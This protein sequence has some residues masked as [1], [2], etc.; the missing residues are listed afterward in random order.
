MAEAERDEFSD[1][2]ESFITQ[3]PDGFFIEIKEPCYQCMSQGYY[4]GMKDA[5]LFE[6]GEIIKGN[7]TPNHELRPLNRAAGRKVREWLDSLPSN[8]VSITMDD[9]IEATVLLSANPKLKDLEPD[10]IAELTRKTAIGVKRKREIA[11][12]IHVPDMPGQTRQS[13][14]VSD[15]PPLTNVAMP[16]GRHPTDLVALNQTRGP[17]MPQVRNGARP[18][19]SMTNAR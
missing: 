12:G 5:T 7:M 4:G 8:G 15:A 3:G 11:L 2:P 17:A 18:T 1:L 9:L 6:E 16:Q 19:P 14:R 10:Q 13:D